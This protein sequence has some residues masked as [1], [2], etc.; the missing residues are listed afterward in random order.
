MAVLFVVFAAA[1]GIGTFVEDA[2]NTETARVYIYNTKWFEAIMLIFVFNFFGNIKRYQLNKKEK[3]ATL[4]LH[5]SFILIIIGAFV[6]RY[7]S[8]EGMMPI[9][10]GATEARFY[11]DKAYLSIWVDGEYQGDTRRRTFEKPLLLTSAEIPFF[12]SN[13]FSMKDEFNKIPFEVEYKDFKL[14]AKETIKED[15]NGVQY[16]KL[17]EQGAG[18]RHDHYLKEGEV[19]NINNILFA[20]NKPTQGAVNINKNGED[21]TVKT[22][23]DG[24]FMRMADRM[25]GG[26]VKDSAQPLMFRSLYNLSG[27]MFVIP[28][29][30]IK[31][32]VAYEGS[33]DFKTKEEAALTVVVKSEGQEKEV[34]LLGGTK[35]VGVPVSFKLGKLEYTMMY[36][37]KTYDLPFS[38]K[39]NDFIAEKYPGTEASYSSYESKITVDDKQQN[40]KFDTRIFMNNVLD[41]GGYRFFQS[42]FDPDEL[43]TNLS[44]SH[45]FWG[46]WI[47]YTGY[48]LLY[49]GLMAILFDKNTRFNDLKVKLDKVRAKKASLTALL[50]LF[51][52]LNGYS[53]IDDHDHTGHNHATETEQQHTH[54]HAMVRTKPT[55][56]QLDSIFNKYKVNE[57]H[58]AKFGRVIIQDFGGRMKP[59]NTFSSELLRKVSKSDTYKGMNADQAFLSMALMDR[60]WYDVPIIYLD[61]GNDSIRK[62]AGIDKTVQYAAMSDFFDDMGNYKLGKYLTE[63]NQ[64]AEKNKFQQDFIALD[65]R[66]NLL[67][68]AISGQ[69]LKVLPVPGDKSNKW[70]SYPEV[71]EGHVKGLDTLKNIIP[72]Y[73]QV[74]GEATTSHDY[75]TA[76]SILERLKEVQKKYGAA[77]MPSDDKIESEVLYNKYDIFKKLY[78]YYALAGIFMFLFVIIKVFKDR[79]GIRIS[80]TFFHGVII[81]LFVLH[82]LGLIARWY[83]SGHAPWSNAYES[84]IYVAWATMFFG[85][86]FGRKSE[87]T[88]ASSAFVAAIVL[89][90]AHGNWTDPDIANLQPVLNSYW[91]MIHVAVIVACYGP[92]TLGMILG[93]VALFLMVFINKNNKLKIELTIKELTYINE[94]ALT[95]GLVMLSI[96]NFLGG[97]WANESW[98]RYWGW[99]PKETWAMVSIMVYAFVIHMRFVPSLRGTWIYNFFSILAYFSILMTYFGVN[100]YLTGLHSYA[101]GERRTPNQFYYM[102]LAACILAGFAYVKYK[103]HLKK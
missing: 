77:V 94:M 45:D 85:L 20:F 19:Q 6:T 87:L 72:F 27:A 9:R 76:D 24:T 56:K 15:P 39:L 91:L 41:Y 97:Q 44:V 10:E 74:L 64:A 73:F 5:L 95:V 4:L 28:D 86:A 92:F 65:K 67:N 69:I 11:S 47:S 88:V 71:A 18:V 83:I 13:H 63:A 14:G 102:A 60:L 16:L 34:T 55:D 7:I 66:I 12:A 32:S 59:A 90:V 2:Y 84:I 50:L 68:W 79:K 49:I 29:H 30:A 38:I 80:V 21:Y 61:R 62:I 48:F 81:F 36:G 58:A 8:F 40:K 89:G 99:D 33:K 37:S 42:G 53:Q 54:E 51:I 25:Q 70:M 101:S 96:G 17:V 93:V 23:F 103:K 22:P 98:G 35:K 1:M 100:F 26:V 43:G 3:W 46:T 52:G 75:K 78:T 57:V 31:G 82:T